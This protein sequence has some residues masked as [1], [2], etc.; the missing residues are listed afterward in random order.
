MD[1]IS[2][3]HGWDRQVMNV[4]G[5]SRSCGWDKEIQPFAYD[6]YCVER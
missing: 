2:K 4:D 6:A 1:G 3:S 5:I